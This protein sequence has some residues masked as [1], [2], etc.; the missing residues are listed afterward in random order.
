[1][2]LYQT[3]E[4]LKRVKEN[5]REKCPHCYSIMENFERTLRTNNYSVARIEKYWSSL[6]TI[7]NLLGKCFDKVEKKDIEDLVIK[8][9]SGNWS[10]W[11]KSDFKKLLKVFYRWLLNKTLEGDYP[12][13]VKWIKPKM[14]KNNEKTPEQVLTREE[15]ELMAKQTENL[16]ERAFANFS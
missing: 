14:K 6:K 4:V 10:E 8:I 3:E 7:H 12:E 5:F 11:T 9:D 2:D 1:M 13:L 15:I 16:M